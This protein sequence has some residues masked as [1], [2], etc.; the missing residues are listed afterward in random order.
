MKLLMMVLL[1]RSFVFAQVP[2]SDTLA[3]SRPVSATPEQIAV[4]PVPVSVKTLAG[5]GWRFDAGVRRAV[6]GGDKGSVAGIS[7][8]RLAKRDSILGNEGYRL[9]INV[10]GVR[11]EA[12]EPA[13]LFYG[14][15]TLLQLLPV[16]GIGVLPAMQII[17]YPRFAWRGLMLDVSRHFFS[18]AVV[19]NYIDQMA[20]YKFNV[21]HWHLSDDQG[22]RIEIKSLPALTQTG[23]W[24]VP[25]TG[26]WWT[27]EP[28]K[29]GEKAGYGGY[30]TQD[31][32]REVVQYAAD[33]FVTVLP[34]ID[35]PGHSLAMIAAYPELSSTGLPYTV[36]NGCKFYGKVD[37]ALCP[38]NEKVF[39]ILDK[40]FSEVAGLFPSPYIHIG[41]DEA[42]K[43]FWKDC[44][45]CNQ[46]MKDENLK[47]VEE[48]QSYFV[49]RLEKMLLA[50]HKKLI[51][52]DEILE[53]GLAP[54]ATVMSWRGMEGGIKAAKQG[55]SVIM[56]PNDHC[57]LD[58]YQ[59][60]PSVEPDTYSRLRLEDCYHFEP[61][62]EGVPASVI[63]G[64]Q[65][66][67]WTESVYNE[68]HAQYMT[69]P[70]SLATAEVLWSP[71]ENKD[72][73]GF[74]RRMEKSF[75]RFDS[76]KVNYALS[77]YD[78]IV[79]LSEENGVKRISIRTEI[80]GL[81]LHY[82]FDNGNPDLFYPSYYTPLSLPPGATWIRVAA[83]RNG[84]QIGKQINLTITELEKRNKE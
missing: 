29:E 51:G 12:N 20:K 77:A 22:W 53:G 21:F 10:H 74:V 34:E 38:G 75:V 28:P 55:H 11:I 23:A 1:F 49:R 47:T 66:N 19:K 13:G 50:K 3:S 17:D 4:I 59:G 35:V 27:F 54:E 52:W 65:A 2:A 39:E 72:W 56:T 24:R 42:M 79:S 30:Y 25:R 26:Q 60:D 81:A 9:G 14:R 37:N 6:A 80:P 40:V 68:R 15:Q 69:W 36:N 64:G 33:R 45:K 76:A 43:G 63:L 62:P 67:L 61:V 78:P 7:F 16:S 32:I 18:K 31:D 46:R 84:K 5:P 82:S 73:K 58:L 71:K 70:R 48:L 8:H 41:G 57:Y 83:F 44:P